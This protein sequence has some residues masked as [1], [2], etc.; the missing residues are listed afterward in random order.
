MSKRKTVS[1]EFLKERGNYFL[2]NS[3]PDWKDQR[4]GVA[5]MIE[6]ALHDT[7]NYQGFSYLDSPYEQGVT[8][9]TRRVYY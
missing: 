4:Q 7:G 3:D 6:V 5:S 2:A 8:D 1:V 9:E